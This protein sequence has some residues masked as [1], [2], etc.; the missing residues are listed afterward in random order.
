MNT[1][2]VTDDHWS[3]SFVRGCLLAGDRQTSPLPW[4]WDNVRQELLERLNLSANPYD[5][6]IW[7]LNYDRSILKATGYE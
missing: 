7:I 6:G 5:Q 3:L 4:N 1:I 2:P